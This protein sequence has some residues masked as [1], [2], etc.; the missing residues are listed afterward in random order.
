[1]GLTGND[2]CSLCQKD[3]ETLLHL[4]CSCQKASSLWKEIS[5]WINNKTS[6]PIQF[7]PLMII[8]GYTNI[9]NISPTINLIIMIILW[10][11]QGLRWKVAIDPLIEEVVISEILFSTLRWEKRSPASEA[12][13][14]E[15]LAGVEVCN[16]RYAENHLLYYRFDLLIRIKTSRCKRL[17]HYCF[18]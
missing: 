3:T 15:A 17:N 16:R 8:I 1:M 5:R 11:Q 13:V 10:H 4:Y 6:I 12:G 9:S 7:D 2:I 18:I 14:L